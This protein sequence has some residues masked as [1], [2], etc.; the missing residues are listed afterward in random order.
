MKYDHYIIMYNTRC[1]CEDDSK[2]NIELITLPCKHHL[3]VE[4]ANQMKT[5]NCPWCRMPMGIIQPTTT[6]NTIQPPP[7]TY[8]TYIDITLCS[9]LIF[10][11]LFLLGF[12]IGNIIHLS[13]FVFILCGLGYVFVW[14]LYNI[15]MFYRMRS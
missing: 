14:I 12:I 9:N 5:D 15:L 1:F 6:N 8:W 13:L 11:L 2:E 10:V 3:H 4:C 7:S